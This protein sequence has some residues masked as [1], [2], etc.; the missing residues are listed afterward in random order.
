MR[1][2][3]GLVAFINNGEARE[4]GPARKAEGN[5]SVS[6]EGYHEEMDVAVRSLAVSMG[7]LVFAQLTPLS[8][9]HSPLSTPTLP[10]LAVALSPGSLRAWRDATRR[11]MLSFRIAQAC[12]GS[13]KER[14]SQLLRRLLYMPAPSL[15][16]HA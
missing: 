4:S 2:R 6:L 9:L 15:L 12:R 10:A 13:G 8:T 3:Q 7:E 16:R 14:S 1:M 5:C 11:R